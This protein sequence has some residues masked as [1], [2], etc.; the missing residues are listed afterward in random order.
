MFN[1]YLTR[2]KL[3][4]YDLWPKKPLNHLDMKNVILFLGIVL[5]GGYH[6]AFS[7]SRTPEVGAVYEIVTPP[8]G[9]TY[10]KVPRQ[11]FILKRGS[12][13]RRN[14]LH[15]TRVILS[16]IRVQKGGTMVLLK[17]ADGGPFF[18]FYGTLS[19]KWPQAI[20]SGELR[21]IP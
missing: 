4:F 13:A 16:K 11:N 2:V 3:L 19:A 5:L 21:A 9:Y 1:Y 8:T 17:R 20:E 15:G 10:L 12:T 6:M 14:S 7:Q 18:R